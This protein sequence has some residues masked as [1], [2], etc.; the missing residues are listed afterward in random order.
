MNTSPKDQSALRFGAGQ[1]PA[2]Q[3]TFG[4]H[5][6]TIRL[7]GGA[8][9]RCELR[10]HTNTGAGA[11]VQLIKDGEFFAGKHYPSMADAVLAAERV[12]QHYLA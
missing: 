4:K 12:R 1:R 7:T 3:P 11:E 8:Q 9:I 10:D 2:P 6:W 5:Q